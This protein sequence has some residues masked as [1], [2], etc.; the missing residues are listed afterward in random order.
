MFISEE[1]LRVV[2]LVARYQSISV[3][4]EHSNKVPSAVSYTVKKLEEA[5]DATLFVRRG[6]YI[7]LTPAGEYFVRHSKQLLND[8]QALKRNTRLVHEGVERE[9]TVAANNIIPHAVL[10]DFVIAFEA[11]FPS[12]ALKLQRE[13]YNGCWDALY[14]RRAQLVIGAPHA[15][16]ASDG[17]I[18]TP[19][20]MLD[21]DFVVGPAH[22]LAR[23]KGPLSNADLRQYPAL[24]LH[25]TAVES[26]PQHAWLL[27]GQKAIYVPDFQFALAVIERNTAVAYLPRHLCQPLLTAGRLVKKELQ[28][29]KH[30]T[31]LFV[32]Y[33]TDG[34]GPALQ[35]C[36]RWL[37]Q[38]G[39]RAALC[40]QSGLPAPASATHGGSDIASSEPQV[41][42]S[43]Q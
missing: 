19:I 32:A 7:S 33:R 10:I 42:A 31:Q 14:N 18:S 9:L 35:W 3:A 11:Q 28:E 43:M 34:A 37:S 16:P 21:W 27:D 17:V 4:A 6:C 22:D 29:S 30:P 5:L 1:T 26:T 12:T 24:C 8:L 25:D 38:P 20:G 23:I 13:I 36:E 40:G 2:Q 15:V 39:L 41:V